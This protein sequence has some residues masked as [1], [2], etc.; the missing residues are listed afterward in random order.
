MK[1]F[2]NCYAGFHV[3]E[4]RG[5]VGE[6]RLRGNNWECPFVEKAEITF[7]DPN[8]ERT[9][10]EGGLPHWSQAGYVCFV[11]W[12]LND[13]LPA[14]VLERLDREIAKLLKDEGFDPNSDWKQQPRP[15]DIASTARGLLRPTYP[16]SISKTSGI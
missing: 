1:Y 13:S 2:T 6:T 16:A 15:A 3:S 11:T 4:R 5:Y 12:R 10:V 8:A 14:D 7:F 9:V